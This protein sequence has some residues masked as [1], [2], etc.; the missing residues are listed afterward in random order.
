M[1]D[2]TATTPDAPR[3]RYWTAGSRGPRLLFIMGFGMRGDIWRPQVEALRER[4]RVAWF[5]NRGIGESERGPQ[6]LW[7]MRDMALD[8]LRVLD[9]LGWRDAHLIGVSMG[10]MVAQEVALLDEPR[11]RSL[12]LIATHE[13]G[14]LRAKLPTPEGIRQFVRS[15]TQTG[16]ARIDAIRRL[17][18]PP[19]FLAAVD[20]DQMK[21]RME[22]QLGRPTPR[23]TLLGQLHAVLRHDTGPRLGQLTLPTLI[24]KPCRDILIRPGSSDRLRRRVAHARLL[25]LPDAGHGAIFQAADTVNEALRRHVADAETL[26][27]ARGAATVHA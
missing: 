1:H 18:Y 7:T 8:T 3:L 25:E 2:H 15:N 16:A 24:V 12:T 9:A 4:H 11:L 22:A 23:P 20:P 14:P 6:R 26:A 21:A 27:L 13:G 17:L 5:D 19:E 10:G